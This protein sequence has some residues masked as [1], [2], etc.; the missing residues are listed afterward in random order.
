MARWQLAAEPLAAVL[1]LAV[2]SAAAISGARRTAGGAVRFAEAWDLPAYWAAGLPA[3]ALAI[4][5]VAALR[6]Q[7]SWRLAACAAAG[8]ALG[9]LIFAPPGTGLGLLP[10]TLLALLLLALLLL[11]AAW[12]GGLIGRLVRRRRA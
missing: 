7:G 6:P 1:G 10:L 2:W 4:A 5:L 8:Q 11:P 3:L 12:L 9:L